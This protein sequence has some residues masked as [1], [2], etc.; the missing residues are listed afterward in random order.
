[1]PSF[2]YRVSGYNRKRKWALFERLVRPSPE[3]TVL[4]VGFNDIE[5]SAT[6]NYIEKHY[7]WRDRITALGIDTPVQF[8]ER[9]PEVKAVQYDGTTFP[10]DDDPFDVC[11]SNAVLE[12]VGRHANRW[13]AQVHFLRE[14]DRVSRTAFITTPNKRFPV[15]VHTRT[16]L[17]HWLPKRWFDGYLRK[18]GQDWAAGD[19]MDLLTK[20]DLVRLLREAGIS[21]YRIIENKI[22]GMTLDFAIAWGDRITADA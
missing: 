17:L 12:H 11:W 9:Y 7:P 22:A 6:D 18:R 16:P 10:F 4:D 2:A 3:L 14:I 19:Y 5:H 15:E 20:R 8:P 1:M 21:D 13:E